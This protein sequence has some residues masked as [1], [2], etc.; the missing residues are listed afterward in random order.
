MAICSGV[1]EKRRA[2]AAGMISSEVINRIPTIFIAMAMTMARS[3]MKTM[4][5]RAG[6]MPSARAISSLTVAARKGRHNQARTASTN[7]PPP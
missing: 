4:R 6:F 3:S 1:E 7:T 5:D 2:G